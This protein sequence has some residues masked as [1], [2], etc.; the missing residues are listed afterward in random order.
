MDVL[1]RD[2]VSELEDDPRGSE[3]QPAADLRW[4]E[5]YPEW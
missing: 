5:R 1:A 3:Y 2:L 4:W